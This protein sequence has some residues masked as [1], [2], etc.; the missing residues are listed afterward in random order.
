MAKKV[1]L[2][3]VAKR[4]GV[5]IGTASRVLNGSPRVSPEACSSV[6]EAIMVLGYL[7][8]MAARSMRK[9]EA[10][11]QNG[12]WSGNI[13]FVMPD[14]DPS[15]LAIPQISG[16]LNSILRELTPEGFQLM[17][18]FPPERS[19]IPH[20]VIDRKVEGM[21]VFG[22]LSAEQLDK[23]TSVMPV[24]VI[25]EV[26]ENCAV[27]SACVDNRVSIFR[28]VQQ[29][30]NAGHRRIAFVN[31]EAEH[32]EFSL[33][34]Q[35]FLETIRKLELPE[36]MV[37]QPTRKHDFPIT[38]ELVCPD[39]EQP[40][41]ELFDGVAEPPTALIVAND[42]QAVGVC[43]ALEKRGIRPGVDVAVIG[44]DNCLL[45]CNLLS[46]TLSSIEYPVQEIGRNAVQ[47]LLSALRNPG[48]DLV[49]RILSPGKLICRESFCPAPEPM[50][51]KAE[52]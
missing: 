16:L 25:G 27:S 20:M 11:S 17:I 38:Q 43:R 48:S 30:K 51:R 52:Q 44:F 24:V 12:V 15:V 42:W 39:M 37:T 3:D 50:S 23:I 10:D 35:V 40:I 2:N 49:S 46:P 45:I 29:L 8:D 6:Q 18:S 47:L 5:S 41:A 31:N 26:P 33:R 19:I 7:P 34:C 28:A 4:A 32:V 36:L 13:G 1:S 14:C 9:K 21:I 22:N